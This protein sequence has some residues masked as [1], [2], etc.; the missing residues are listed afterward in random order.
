MRIEAEIAAVRQDV[1]AVVDGVQLP[2]ERRVEVVPFDGDVAVDAGHDQKLFRDLDLI[3]MA[4]YAHRQLAARIRP[5]LAPR[6]ARFRALRRSAETE[7]LGAAVRVVQVQAEGAVSAVLAPPPEDVGLTG[8]GSFFAAL[9]YARFVAFRLDFVGARVVAV[10]ASAAGI[11]VV[12]EVAAVALG[13]GVAHPTS[14]M[15]RS[16]MAQQF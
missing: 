12:A 3:A 1:I 7:A 8:T 14:A 11:A 4:F 5:Y 10:A 9:A 6:Q 15:A 2:I 13:A 16:R